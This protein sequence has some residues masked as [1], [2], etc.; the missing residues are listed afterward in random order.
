LI[1][2]VRMTDGERVK[3]PAPRHD[4]SGIWD[5]G[6]DPFRTLG[7]LGASAIPD[8]GKPEHELPYTPLGR[9][10]LNRTEQWNSKR[11]PCGY[12]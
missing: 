8:D 1:D 4:I 11:S 12:K 5:P 3:S 2:A 6:F 7:V 10:A 9:E